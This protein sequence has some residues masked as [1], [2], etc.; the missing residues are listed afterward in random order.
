M[1][2]IC[3]PR[4]GPVRYYNTDEQDYQ[5]H[6]EWNTIS[7]AA[8]EKGYYIMNIVGGICF[9]IAGVRIRCENYVWNLGVEKW[10]K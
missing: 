9:F 5:Y 6:Y 1:N 4:H 8:F 2:E 3:I 10:A 7:Y